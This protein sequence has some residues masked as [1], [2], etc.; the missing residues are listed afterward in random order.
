MR[1]ATIYRTMK[2]FWKK[3]KNQ[4][5]ISRIIDHD[6]KESSQG[7]KRCRSRKEIYN[8]KPHPRISYPLKE[9]IME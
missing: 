9:Q 3:S 8:K 1:E 6:L 2:T 4:L 5:I 7:N